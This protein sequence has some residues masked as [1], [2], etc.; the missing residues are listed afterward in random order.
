MP[1]IQV[2]GKLED[3]TWGGGFREAVNGYQSYMNVLMSFNS[4][5]QK[6][7]QQQPSTSPNATIRDYPNE[8]FA[9]DC[10]LD[11]FTHKSK[12]DYKAYIEKVSGLPQEQG[13]VLENYISKHNQYLEEKGNCLKASEENYTGCESRCKSYPPSTPAREACD[14]NCSD[15][16]KYSD[17]ECIRLYC[18]HDCN[19]AN[20]CN[21]NMN[22]IYSQFNREF[23]EYKDKQKE[24][25]DDLYGFTDKWISRI[26][27]PYWSKIYAYEIGRV[28]LIIIGNVYTAY[29]QGFQATVKSDCGSSCSDFVI[30]PS[31]PVAKVITKEMQE[32]ECS[33]HER[34]KVGFGICELGFDCESVEFGCTEI[35]S[36]SV[37]RNF[38]KKTT[39]G[40]LGVGV[41]AEAGIVGASA[42]AGVVVTLGDNNEIVDVGGKMEGSF[43]AGIG[44]ARGH[45]TSSATYTVMT[46]F[47]TQASAGGF[48]TGGH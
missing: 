16:R 23:T 27:S 44:P 33:E 21:A 5:F 48:G 3:W 32:N 28:A 40:F 25:L 24:T 38:K 30:E 12:K 31:V 26:H 39:T 2:V 9:I 47:S 7:H 42:K 35:L 18:L 10:M 36:A 37:E 46:G 15:L 6:V 19:A 14:R 8:R 20:E 4:E 17:S 45:V 13:N 43:N 29:P 41:E 22:G 1:S 11:Y 34:H